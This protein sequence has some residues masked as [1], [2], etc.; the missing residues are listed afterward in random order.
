M[1]DASLLPD[2][3]A[4]VLAGGRGTRL[5]SAV[6][7]RP[8]VLAD[9]GGRPFLAWLLD[10]IAR[11]GI[12][13]AVLCTGYR[14]DQVRTVFGEAFGDLRIA[15]SHESEP[16]GTAGALRLAAD[17]I[18]FSTALVLNG[19]SYCEADLGAFDG[20]HRER[21]AQASILLTDVPDTSRYGRIRMAPGNAVAG[22]EEKQPEAGPGRINAGVYR[23]ERSVVEGIPS[24]R[25][26]SLEREVFPTLVGRGLYG[27]P[28]GGRFIDI[29]VPDDYA[30]SARFFARAEGEPA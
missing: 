14:G 19:D 3:P 2:V 11:A 8:K 9:V 27:F 5:Q 30:A 4:I 10:A 15:Y 22:F 18:A 24:G 23:I 29:G 12:R 13:R 21:G 20:F 16:M 28:G 26:V 6:A 1:C 17:R 7:D 25:S